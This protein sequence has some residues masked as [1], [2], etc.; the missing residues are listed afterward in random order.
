MDS[1]WRMVELGRGVVDFPA[2]FEALRAAGYE[3]WIVDDFYYTGYAAM[4]SSA[5]CRRYLGE[6]LGLRGRR[7]WWPE[8]PLA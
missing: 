4:E 5:V 8:D 7:G 2:C 6:A 3:G 1:K